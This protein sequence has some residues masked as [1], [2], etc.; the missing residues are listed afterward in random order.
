MPLATTM[1]LSISPVLTGSASEFSGTPR[2]APSVNESLSWETGTGANQADLMWADAARSIN[3][4]S[5]DDLDL[6]GG[7]TDALGNTVTMLRIKQ[8]Y[9]KNNETTAG[10][11]LRVGA[12][13]T[14]PISTLFGAT[15][16]YIIIPPTGWLWLATGDATA[17]ALTGGSADVLRVANPGASAVTYDI[18]VIGSSA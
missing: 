13:G 5:N 3:A 7:L 6:T 9:I 18:I 17:W 2:F 14:N 12:A 16:D 4:A 11:V 1:Q 15:A 8:I 10:R